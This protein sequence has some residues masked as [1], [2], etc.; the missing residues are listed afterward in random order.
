MKFFKTV[1]GAFNH[2]KKNAQTGTEKELNGVFDSKPS[3]N[4][5]K[6]LIAKD[7]RLVDYF[8]PF[9]SPVSSKIEHKIGQL[10]AE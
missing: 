10:L 4:F 7:G 2:I 3:W 1:K 5:H 6:Y 9:T 8:Y